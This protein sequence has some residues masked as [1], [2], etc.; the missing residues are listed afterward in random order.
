MFKLNSEEKMKICFFGNLQT[1][2]MQRW[3][4]S[5]IDKG[6]EVHI[7]TREPSEI[8]DVHVHVFISHSVSSFFYKIPI[9]A[10]LFY[11]LHIYFEINRLKKLINKINPDLINAHYLTDYGILASKLNFH[12]L[13]IT[14]WGSDILIAPAKF[15]E[16]HVKEMRGSLSNADKILVESNYM[17]K[18]IEKFGITEEK[19]ILNPCG[20]DTNMFNPK[21]KSIDLRK[22][23]DLGD[24][25]VLITTRNLED[26]YNQ[27]CLLKAIPIVKKRHPKVNLL[28]A[29]NGSKK[30]ELEKIVK[31]LK[32]KENVR[33]LEFIDHHKL[34]SYLVSSN[35]YISTALSEGIGKSNLEA[36]SC[37]IITIVIDLPVVHEYITSGITGFIVNNN[38]DELAE[39][40][41]DCID[42]SVKYKQL[43]PKNSIRLVNERY[44]WSKNIDEIEELY[45]ELAKNSH[46][47]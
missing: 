42:N 13:V 30:D 23:H 31:E 41:I 22:L 46:S 26:I 7:I 3:A 29:G 14:C 17:K 35:I 5:F 40:I 11:S 27:S 10:R 2:H 15:G 1:I 33:F 24:G 18:E 6:H 38:P 47:L 12:P 36:L 28:V 44:N 4:K 20:V 19:I 34:P 39:R 25:P 9:I 37:G 43:L 45:C 8:A 16:K 32:I 21:A